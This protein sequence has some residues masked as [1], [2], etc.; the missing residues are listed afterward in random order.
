M[1][2]NARPLRAVVRDAVQRAWQRAIEAGTLPA[3]PA[4]AQGL[5]V[6]VERPGD[7]VHGD[8]A[9]NLAL[10]L[11]R[12]YRR[13]PLEIARALAD[14]LRA[15][16]A[17][18]HATMDSGD[19]DALFRSVEVAPPGFVNLVLADEVVA[20]S[21]AAVLRAGPAYGR[22]QAALPQRFDV[23]F[24]S[25]NPTGPLHVGN[26]RGAFVGDFLCRILD[27]AGHDVF[28]E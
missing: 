3:L 14:A 18:D 28:R 13:S 25:A 19:A 1:A 22:V 2:A 26:A 11:A 4:E 8:F 21:V 10:K 6:E 15:T 24:V 23:E 20:E 27:A 12:P 5:Q 16:D 7:P 9:S 17:G